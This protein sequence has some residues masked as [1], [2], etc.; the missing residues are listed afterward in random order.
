MNKKSKYLFLKFTSLL[1]FVFYLIAN[2]AFADVPTGKCTSVDGSVTYVTLT[3]CNSTIPPGTWERGS[4][5]GAIPINTGN[6]APNPTP[7]TTTTG[8]PSTTPKDGRLVPC[9]N[10]PDDKGAIASADEC[11]FYSLMTLIYNVIQFILFAMVV[12]I[13]AIMFAYAG[14]LM[15]TSGGSPEAKTKAKGIFTSVVFGLIIAIAAWLIINTI[16]R[17]VGFDGSW[18]GFQ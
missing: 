11:N 3:Q 8:A 4:Y 5:S 7:T 12:P 2:T 1:F 17:I 9:N 15:V 10:T 6:P 13:A 16:L 14:F 18:I